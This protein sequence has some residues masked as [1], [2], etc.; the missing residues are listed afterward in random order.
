[1]LK[2]CQR[3]IIYLK[4]TKSEYFSEAYF[5]LKERAENAQENDVLKE[6][7]RLLGRTHVEGKEKKSGGTVKVLH[8]LLGILS[9]FLLTLLVGVLVL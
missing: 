7:E 9:G 3:K 1:M 2:G 4:N 6:A 8:F 5:V